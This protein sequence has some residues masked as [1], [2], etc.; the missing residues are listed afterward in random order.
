[1]RSRLKQVENVA[2]NIKKLT[3]DLTVVTHGVDAVADGTTNI[4]QR[5]LFGKSTHD[6][7]FRSGIFI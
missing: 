7:Y 5:G 3:N 2:S 4:A 6:K 1:M